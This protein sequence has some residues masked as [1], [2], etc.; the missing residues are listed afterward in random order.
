MS[1]NSA[2]HR[3]FITRFGVFRSKLHFLV[4]PDVELTY[5][6]LMNIKFS[7]VYPR[8]GFLCDFWGFLSC[9]AE[10]QFLSVVRVVFLVQ[11]VAPCSRWLTFSCDGCVFWHWGNF[12]SGYGYGEFFFSVQRARGEPW[13]SGRIAPLSNF[14]QMLSLVVAETSSNC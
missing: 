2:Y 11:R 5:S 4:R 6:T 1:T 14:Q 12:R 13:K 3:S 9:L 8:C 10:S 7:V